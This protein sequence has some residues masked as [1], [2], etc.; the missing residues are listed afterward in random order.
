MNHL[1]TTENTKTIDSFQNVSS[2]DIINK[3]E[4]F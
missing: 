2:L 4:E 1:S 3:T